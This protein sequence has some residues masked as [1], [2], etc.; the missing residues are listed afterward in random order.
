MDKK[1]YLD[2]L[3]R[4]W[5]FQVDNGTKEVQLRKQLIN[6]IR[7]FFVSP[8]FGSGLDPRIVSDIIRRFFHLAGE[9]IT[10]IGHDPH[11][12]FNYLRSS[13]DPRIF[14]IRL[15][16]FFL[17]VKETI[18]DS[19]R[20]EILFNEM[21]SD[22]ICAGSPVEITRYE[23]IPVIYPAGAK[24]LD[25]ALVNDVFVWL[26][27]FTK[28][29]KH[30]KEALEKYNS[31]EIRHCLDELRKSFEE[32]LREYFGNR[33][34]LEKQKMKIDQLFN[35]AKINTKIKNVFFQIW[36]YYV[37]YQNDDVKHGDKC[38]YR[39]IEFIL[40]VLKKS[41]FDRITSVSENPRVRHQFSPRMADAAYLLVNKRLRG[42]SCF[43][44]VRGKLRAS[45]GFSS[46]NTFSS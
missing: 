38:E 7:D 13:D 36:K 46:S 30:L 42:N 5:E 8:R 15:G 43:E 2:N 4:R 6:Q 27:E 28:A 26:S 18:S 34:S 31:E 23:G 45:P 14:Y 40:R 39:D 1:R 37:D 33:K 44:F 9:D 22:I 35:K 10:K 32:F 21:Q 20:C 19:R 25:Q 29:R 12:M 41:I 3:M 17:A 16:F 24:E 11:N